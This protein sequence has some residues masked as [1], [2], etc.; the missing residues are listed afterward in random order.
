METSLLVLI[1]ND[2]VPVVDSRV[3][4]EKCG[5]EQ[6]SFRQLIGDYQA[7]IEQ[8]FGRVRFENDT[9]QTNG[10]PQKTTFSL[11][12]EDQATFIITLTRNTA[13]VIAF[14]ASLVKAFAEAKRQLAVSAFHIP[15]TL[16]EALRLAAE[17]AEQAE[18]LALENAQHQQ[19][20]TRMA[21]KEEFFDCAMTSSQG[22]LVRDA[23]KLLH[24]EVKGGMGEHRL[25]KWL[26]AQKWIYTD[27]YGENRP[28]Q[29]YVDLHYLSV[30]ERP[31]PTDHGTVIKVTPRITQQGL[32]ALNRQLLGKS[33]ARTH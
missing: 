3:V 19:T 17:K 32:V 23:A 33:P 20:I 6:K 24:N 12:T 14:K 25:Y 8:A 1:P 21:P 15:Q 16:P 30:T 31:I 11:L 27:A 13:Q 29:R 5:V 22:M 2:G 4:A 10:G 26:R 7:T 28:Y 18:R 9:L